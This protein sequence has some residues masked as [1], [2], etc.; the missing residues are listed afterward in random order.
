MMRLFLTVLALLTGIAAANSQ[1]DTAIKIF[2]G[3]QLIV[4]TVVQQE[5]KPKPQLHVT[6]FILDDGDSV[7][8]VNLPPVQIE[9]TLNPILADNM[10]L[11]LRLKRD[12]L[13]AYPYAKIASA[14]LIAVNDS[15][16]LF[17]KSKARKKYIK[18]S[19]S[20]MKAEFEEE[21]KRLT[22]NQGK[23]LIKLV[24]R[25]TGSTGYE[26]VKELRGPFQAM[27]WQSMAKMFG[28]T[29][30]MEYD[31]NG[32]DKLIEGIV[33]SIESGE[34]PVPPRRTAQKKG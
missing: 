24:D 28:S 15:L 19:E 8:V 4:D 22:V 26:I 27:F 30:K 34:I 25:E 16:S 14:K 20:K 12:V 17:K 1:S 11:Y 33:R 18:E 5:P 23:I 2:K 10:K 7:P 9:D 32:E 3:G 31:P 21:L 29:L 6:Y 13:R